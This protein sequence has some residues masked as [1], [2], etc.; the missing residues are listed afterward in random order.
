[1]RLEPKSDL[2]SRGVESPDRADALIG[3]VMMRL[4]PDPYAFDPAGRQAMHEMMQQ[5][6]R[7]ME[8]SQ[9][10]GYVEHVNWDLL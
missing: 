4:S 8:Q 2:A 3:S 1:L 6:L 10:I 7:Q 9:P 5:T